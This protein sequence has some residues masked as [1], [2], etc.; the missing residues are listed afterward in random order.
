[1]PRLDRHRLGRWGVSTLSDVVSPELRQYGARRAKQ[2]AE[3]GSTCV[4]QL[5]GAASNGDADGP[6]L[7]TNLDV[8]EDVGD[9]AKEGAVVAEG[10]RL[11]TE[12]AQG[13]GG[14]LLRGAA[15]ILFPVPHSRLNAASCPR[16]GREAASL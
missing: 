4:R 8:A 1:M 14:C 16:R 5:Q 15:E 10:A 3:V 9:M 2:E 7:V 11:A 13:Q 12:Y 6:S